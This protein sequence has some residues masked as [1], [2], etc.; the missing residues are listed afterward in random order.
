[1]TV[2][3]DAL[4]FALGGP[5][6]SARIKQQPEDFRVDEVLGFVPDG[7]GEHAF[8]QIEK[9]GANTEWV[10]RALARFAGVPPMAVGFA[11]L[12]DRHAITRQA[13]T[14]HL[15]GRPDPDWFSANI[16]GVQVLSATRHK[17][18]LPRGALR[19]NRFRMVLRDCGVA[20][21]LLTERLNRIAEVGVP[22]YFGEQ[23]FGRE[24]GNIA[25]ALAMF[26]G[27]RVDRAERGILLSAAR[28][29]I[30]NAVLAA[31]VEARSWN[32]ACAGDV[33]QIDGSG[34]IFGPEPITEDIQNRMT[35]GRIHATGPM[36]GQ[37]ELRTAGAVA[38]Q[39]GVIAAQHAE[40]A[41]G[42]ATAGLRQERRALRL[43]VG[44]LEASWE[45]ETAVLTFELPA[46]AF[47]TVVLREL[48]TT[49]P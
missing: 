14:V 11:G 19:G 13:Y 9:R 12:K 31:R 15:P 33:F 43:R 24:G 17:R 10:A 8:L 48:I 35:Q 25:R 26:A 36:W 3:V 23:R 42:L 20:S 4:P 47:A 1:M 34:S 7:Q 30:F 39:E 27:A 32:Q 5:L 40:L 38:E 18:K 41:T 29:Q 16:E 46:G 22:N 45:Q 28:S 49:V 37:G 6:G 2:D 21:A 44:S